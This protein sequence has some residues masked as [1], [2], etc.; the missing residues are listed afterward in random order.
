MDLVITN[1]RPSKEYFGALDGFR[2]VLAICVAIYHTFWFSNLNGTAF[3]NNGPVVIDLFFVFSGFLLFRLYAEKIQTAEGV[4]IF[5]KR[6]FARLYPLHIFTLALFLG[7]AVLR[8]AAHKGGISTLDPGETLPFTPGATE[9]IWS[10]ISNLTLTHSMG[11]HE[12]LSFNPPSWTISVEFFAYIIFA[13]WLYWSPP[14]SLGHILVICM[15]IGLIY[16]GL[17]RVKPNMDITY[18]YG[19]FR[20]LGGFYT[21]VVGAWIY[22]QSQSTSLIGK[23]SVVVATLFE[24][25]ALVA[26]VSFVI[27]CPGKLQFLV[28]PF[29]LLFIY[30]FAFDRGY[31]SRFMSQTLFRYLAKISYSV[32]MIHALVSIIALIF[33]QRVLARIWGTQWL[34]TGW[35]G[36]I[37]LIPYL[38][39]VIGISHLTW[40]FVERPGKRFIEGW[41]IWQKLEPDAKSG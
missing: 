21:G 16:F 14:K 12:A 8:L 28:A 15:G 34:E 30:V 9:T 18:D 7:F 17:S 29:A 27:Y 20:C 32:Y 13:A 24:L 31:I 36:D 4:M 41:K 40:T 39:I 11:F 19:F 23:A 25:F 6:R 35:A 1:H 3:F 38:I 10:L 37:Y 2:G 33:A 5:F 22:G 26:Y